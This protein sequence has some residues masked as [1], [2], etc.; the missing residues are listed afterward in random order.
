MSEH[1]VA[2]SQVTFTRDKRINKTRVS[3]EA[4]PKISS[5]I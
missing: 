5:V 3:L 2:L 4:M 1:H